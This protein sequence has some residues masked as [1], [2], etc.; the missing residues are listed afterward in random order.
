MQP[1]FYAPIGSER[2]L[3]CPSWGF[4]AGRAL[5]AQYGGSIPAAVAGGQQVVLQS[6]SEQMTRERDVLRQV[7]EVEWPS[8]N[9]SFNTSEF[10]LGLASA[11]SVPLDALS[12]STVADGTNR[13][14]LAAALIVWIELS[15]VL[16]T[17]ANHS[18]IVQQ[19]QAVSDTQLSAKLG[20]AL[21][22]QS[23]ELSRL[24]SNVTRTVQ[25]PI[26]VS[27]PPGFWG[28]DGRCVPCAP[29]SFG[30]GSSITECTPCP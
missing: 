5:D 8:S 14:R 24:T 25:R 11:Y 22:T 27:C 23:V 12:L 21:R 16:N 20:Y 7:I 28:A 10:L 29:G 9:H 1:G 13:R 4:C 26:L 17:T 19:V 3:P 15:L 30:N 6:V 18:E 2:P